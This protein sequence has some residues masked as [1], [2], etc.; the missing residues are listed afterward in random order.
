MLYRDALSWA[1]EIAAG[2]RAY[3]NDRHCRLS[4]EAVAITV[5][6]SE[7]RRRPIANKGELCP[8]GNGWWFI[9]LRATLPAAEESITIGHELCHWWLKLHGIKL[10]RDFEEALCDAVG[11][12]LAMP[13]EAF[14]ELVAMVGYR[15]YKLAEWFHTTRRAALLRLSE[16][17]GRPGL[18][19]EYGNRPRIIRG[20][21]FDWPEDLRTV[22]RSE[23][24]LVKV[25]DRWGMLAVG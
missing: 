4:V 13:E 15:V 22:P 18:V 3:A 23:A 12:R 10:D 25:E 7:I 20:R 8:D 24:H 21:P 17:T 6:R 1:D 2:I 16:T 5:F 9:T 19:K 11:A 14:C